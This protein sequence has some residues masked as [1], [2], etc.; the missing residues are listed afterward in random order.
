MYHGRSRMFTEYG[1]H[2]LTHN[3]TLE[4]EYVT[5]CFPHQTCH[6]KFLGDSITASACVQLMPI[7]PTMKGV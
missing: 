4:N 5:L 3:E 7:W 6:Q 1:V 2:P